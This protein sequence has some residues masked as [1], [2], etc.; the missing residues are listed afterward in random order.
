MENDQDAEYI[1]NSSKLGKLIVKVNQIGKKPVLDTSLSEILDKF[2]GYLRQSEDF[3]SHGIFQ[4]NFA[5]AALLLQSSA[6][7]YSKKVDLLWESIIQCQKRM[8]SFNIEENKEELKKLEEREQK[9][10]RKRKIVEKPQ[11][12]VKNHNIESFQID[13]DDVTNGINLHGQKDSQLYS[14]W[15]NRSVINLDPQPSLKGNRTLYEKMVNFRGSNNSIYDKD[16]DDEFVAHTS[17]MESVIRL[18]ALIV[19]EKQICDTFSFQIFTE[20]YLMPKFLAQYELGYE[21]LE[22]NSE[23]YA[24][25]VSSYKDQHFSSEADRVTFKSTFSELRQTPQKL[26]RISINSVLSSKLSQL[27]LDKIY[28]QKCQVNL[29]RLSVDD[30]SRISRLS[31]DEVR[32]YSDPMHDMENFKIKTFQANESS[33]NK[34]IICCDDGPPALECV[35]NGHDVNNPLSNIIVEPKGNDTNVDSTA[36][37]STVG[38]VQEI[39]PS[40]PACTQEDLISKISEKNNSD[41]GD[42]SEVQ[43]NNKPIKSDCKREKKKLTYNTD[44]NLEDD[45]CTP[46]KRRRLSKAALK[47]LATGITVDL[48]S[49]NHFFAAHYTPEEGEGQVEVPEF[50]INDPVETSSWIDPQEGVPLTQLS[51]NIVCSQ[52]SGYESRIDESGLDHENTITPAVANTTNL[53]EGQPGEAG[54]SSENIDSQCETQSQE[55]ELATKTN[56]EDIPLHQ[57]LYEWKQYMSEKFKQMNS[58]D[59][60]IHEYGSNIMESISSERPKQFGEIVQGKSSAEVTRYFISVLQL[61]NTHNIEIQGIQSGKLSNETLSLKLITKERCYDSLKDYMAPSEENYQE[62]FEKAK[63]LKNKRCYPSSSKGT[64]HKHGRYE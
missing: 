17:K 1:N 60:D 18:E 54:P 11:H 16:E 7:V 57:K 13:W 42:A 36:N 37:I 31:V 53:S 20:L 55:S 59:F 21:D 6:F 56:E 30:L 28:A 46:T 48:K 26:R 41:V 25:Y 43:V 49:F 12:K 15:Y 47:K 22:K 62:R 14:E 5:E 52:D 8:I 51:Q 23:K 61:A 34:E 38:T 33:D 45:D 44:E 39:I 2:H 64:N 4:I 63:N 58:T 24:D 50:E 10:K 3:L 32:H 35:D 29:L 9:Y 40:L 19:Q 27:D